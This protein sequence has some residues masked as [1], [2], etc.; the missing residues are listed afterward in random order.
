[1]I[2]PN[3]IVFGGASKKIYSF[4]LDTKEIKILIEAGAFF[5]LNE[6]CVIEAK[7]VEKDKN[8]FLLIGFSVPECSIKIWNISNGKELGSLCD[9]ENLSTNIIHSCPR[10]S[11]ISTIGNEIKLAILQNN[12][13]S[14]FVNI[15][16]IKTC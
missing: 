14:D 9:I 4:N 13:L 1:M 5:I 10:M 6:M 8:S 11:I 12:P 15:F 16:T 3:H 2:F 7:I